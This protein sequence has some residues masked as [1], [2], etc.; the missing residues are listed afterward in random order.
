[1]KFTMENN[2]QGQVIL[3]LLTGT[4]KLKERKQFVNVTN[5]AA[6]TV[7]RDETRI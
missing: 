7:M 3:A 6:C 2:L 1:M 5:E 4:M